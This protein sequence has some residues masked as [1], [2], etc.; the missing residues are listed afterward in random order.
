MAFL[1]KTI[2]LFVRFRIN[3]I[4]VTRLDDG[5][6][7]AADAAP[8]FSNERIVL[9]DFFVAEG[10]LKYLITQLIGKRTFSPRIKMVVQQMDRA[11]GGLSSVERRA[12]IDSCEHAGAFHVHV[13]DHQREL[14]MAEALNLLER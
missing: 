9:A 11:E 14:T 3:R 7:V 2:P 5:A 1:F 13:V 12:L 10:L 8:P 6:S 4:E